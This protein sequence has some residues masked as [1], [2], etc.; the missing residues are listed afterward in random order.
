MV[1]YMLLHL[2]GKK[3]QMLDCGLDMSDPGSIRSLQHAKGVDKST[4]S[5]MKVC[6]LSEKATKQPFTFLNGRPIFGLQR[7]MYKKI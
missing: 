4:V 6:P 3:P 7:S 1:N 5:R 2:T